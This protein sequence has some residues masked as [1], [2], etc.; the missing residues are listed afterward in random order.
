MPYVQP[1]ST[2]WV[3]R[4]V[5]LDKGYNHTMNFGGA[6]AQFT[7]FTEESGCLL[8]TFTPQTYQRVHKNTVR[9][10]CNA[11]ELLEVNYMI[12]RN[13]RTDGKS[14]YFYCFIDM[15]EYVNENCTEISYTIDVMQTYLFDFELGSCFV[16]REHTETDVIGDNLV[17]ENLEIGT[18]VTSEVVDV[19]FP[20]MLG[21]IVLSKPLPETVAITPQSAGAISYY[22]ITNTWNPETNEAPAGVPTQLYYY[23]G[24]PL[25]RND[26]KNK[27]DEEH[28]LYEMQDFYVWDD[29][30]EPPQI[31][32]SDNYL[33]LSR[34]LGLI[35]DG[36]VPNL[37]TNDIVYCY[38]YPAEMSKIQYQAGN[39]GGMCGHA[40]TS[41]R[42]PTSFI[43]GGESYTPKN[44][45]LFTSPYVDIMVS[46]KMG[47]IAKFK[48]EDFLNSAQPQFRWVGNITSSP[49]MLCYP[50]NHKNINDDYESG[51][52]LSNFPQP[53]YTGSQYAAWIEQNR[54]SVGLSLVSGSIAT[55][56]R[57]AFSG[58]NPA[59]LIGGFAPLANSVGNL[60]A[61]RGN[62]ESAPPQVQGQV[63]ADTINVGFDR[64]GFRFYAQSIKPEFARIVDDYFSMFG[65]AINKVK[66]P[67]IKKQGASLRP[68]WNYVKTKGCIIHPTRSTTITGGLP[69]DAENQIAKIFDNGITFWSSTAGF[70]VVG[71]YSY[72]NNPIV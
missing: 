65:Y 32:D 42:R 58:G 70:A 33:T 31:E 43:F 72:P 38:I 37:S 64:T 48:F 1:N 14:K 13:V 71:D 69:S 12:F 9:V 29:T 30:P 7:Y 36:E 54:Y 19:N 35:G 56:S 47:N 63:V 15:V 16:E 67:N 41:V 45:K 57:V 52:I 8:K 53:A 11:T 27:W 22:K 28:L 26:V 21:G 44:N 50:L 10:A 18:T 62:L 6:T 60:I 34:I 61:Q 25:S 5:P 46:N 40:F 55:L 49:T 4:G 17:P 51:I 39:R 23:C 20:Y 2:V 59:A 68:V 3:F 66:V 24:F